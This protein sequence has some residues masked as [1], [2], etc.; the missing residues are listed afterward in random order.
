MTGP[1]QTRQDNRKTKQDKTC[2]KTRPERRE[3]RR[4]QNETKTNL[5]TPSNEFQYS[6]PFFKISSEL[7]YLHRNAS[8]MI[9]YDKRQTKTRPFSVRQRQHKGKDKTI[10]RQVWFQRNHKRRQDRHIGRRRWP[11]HALR[12]VRG[13]PSLS[14]CMRFGK[15]PER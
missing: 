14:C 4:S 3:D 5:F 2:D 13:G 8:S 6:T 11:P 15:V 9:R 12:V 7:R 1:N 10:T